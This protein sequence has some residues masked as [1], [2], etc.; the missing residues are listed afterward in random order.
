MGLELFFSFCQSFMIIDALINIH[1]K[2]IYW[3]N[4]YFYFKFL[5]YKIV[6]LIRLNDSIYFLLN[7]Q[8]NI[9]RDT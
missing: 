4:F 2:Y 3:R 8:Q 7:L 6:E 1:V 9:K 5:F